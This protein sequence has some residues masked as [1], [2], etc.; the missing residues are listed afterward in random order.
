MPSR[1]VLTFD[2]D[3]VLCRPPFGIN[4]GRGVN[5]QRTGEGTKS[6]LWQ[7]ERWRY[8][9]RRPM[10]GAAA[11]FRAL[12]AEYDCKILSARSADAVRL[13]GDWFERYIGLRPEMYLRP[14]WHEKPA[15]Y[16]ARMVVELGAIAHFEDDAHTAQW[17]AE[18]LPAVFLVDWWR[19]RWLE[20][21]NVHRIHRLAN[22]I[23]TLKT[24]TSDRESS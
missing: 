21:E 12:A 16:K 11:G 3:G 22:A 24:L 6:V 18:L 17:V 4:P 13:T 20:A 23:P 1:P 7:T 10:P 14:D 15:Q 8:R 5:K 2:L 19:N 9:G